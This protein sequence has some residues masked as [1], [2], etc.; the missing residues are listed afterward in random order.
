VYTFRYLE[1]VTEMSRKL[2]SISYDEQI[3]CLEWANTYKELLD[4]E[5]KLKG[6]P[7]ATTPKARAGIEEKVDSLRDRLVSIQD[8]RDAYQQ[9]IQLIM[10]RCTLIKDT[11]RHE[12]D[13]EKLRL[14]MT[15]R[16]QSKLT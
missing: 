12:A 4:M 2:S 6:L 14:E 9:A 16:V 7:L 8:Q 13:L 10:E 11:V 3:V 15:A 1:E 5:E